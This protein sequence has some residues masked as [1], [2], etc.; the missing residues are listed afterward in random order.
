MELMIIH[1][2]QW[3]LKLFRICFINEWHFCSQFWR[4]WIH[5]IWN[6][7]VAMMSSGWSVW[8]VYDL[9]NNSIDNSIIPLFYIYIYIYSV[10]L[11]I[12]IFVGFSENKIFSQYCKR[13][14]NILLWITNMAFQYLGMMMVRIAHWK[15]LKRKKVFI[16]HILSFLS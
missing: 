3:F 13:L 8:I 15:H 9:N 10:E 11:I 12:T 16:F 6:V 5:V 1:Y 7:F 14:R 2:R 4:S